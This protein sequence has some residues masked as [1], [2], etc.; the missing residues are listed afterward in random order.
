MLLTAR[1]DRAQSTT[2][3]QPVGARK[4]N[5]P[6][7]I[8]GRSTDPNVAPHPIGAGTIGTPNPIM[9]PMLSWLIWLIGFALVFAAGFATVLVPRRRASAR[10]RQTA[11]SAAR[12]AI[13]TA[14]VS[15]DAAPA[16]VAEAEQLLARAE[17]IAAARGGRA[18]ADQAADCAQQADRLWRASRHG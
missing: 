2:Q 11:W 13:D 15:R 3:G 10:D 18:A 8:N 4:G 6:V 16:R 14:S 5:G 7:R 9:E 17:S 12:A 1:T